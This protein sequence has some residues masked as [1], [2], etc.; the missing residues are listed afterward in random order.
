MH[1]AELDLAG[2][3]VGRYTLV[4]TVAD[5]LVSDDHQVADRAPTDAEVTVADDPVVLDPHRLA[6]AD[7]GTEVVV[8]VI[9]DDGPTKAGGCLD[10]HIGNCID[11]ELDMG[12]DDTTAH[13]CA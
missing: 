12:M 11:V 2:F 1:E 3:P 7:T 6:H 5:D 9:A 8:D 13:R 10:E 4:M